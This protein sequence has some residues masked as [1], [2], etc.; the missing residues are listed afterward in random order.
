MILSK[1]SALVSRLNHPASIN[2]RAN[3]IAAARCTLEEIERVAERGQA[4]M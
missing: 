4:G 3:L 1:N 2:E